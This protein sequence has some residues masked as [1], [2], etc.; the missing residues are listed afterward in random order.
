MT[1]PKKL[2]GLHFHKKVKKSPAAKPLSKKTT[3]IRNDFNAPKNWQK[4]IKIEFEDEFLNNSLLIN[5][6]LE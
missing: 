6:I 5:N 2:K 4:N 1:I 3:L